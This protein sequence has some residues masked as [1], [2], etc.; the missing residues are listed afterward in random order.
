MA[1]DFGDGLILPW[2][3]VDGGPQIDK[4]SATLTAPDAKPNLC[5]T[6]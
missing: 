3:K 4:L 5:C 6:H 1:V 2:T